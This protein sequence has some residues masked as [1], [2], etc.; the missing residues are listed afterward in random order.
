[1]SGRG[2]AIRV[3][4]P[5]TGEEHQLTVGL[6]T[7]LNIFRT[8][9]HKL[10]GIAVRGRRAWG[11]RVRVSRRGLLALTRRAALRPRR[12]QPQFQVLQLLDPRPAEERDFRDPENVLFEDGGGR[13]FATL[14]ALGVAPGAA[15]SLHSLAPPT[16]GRTA[17]EDA[18]KARARARDALRRK[19]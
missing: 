3:R 2:A 9:L 12:P 16:P 1:M 14:G 10:T 4:L 18:D 8:Q 7:P 11:A 13:S 5:V 19:R 15:L 17:P 6:H